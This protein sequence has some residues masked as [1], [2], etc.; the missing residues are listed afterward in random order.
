MR[1]AN[2]AYGLI[3]ASALM[4]VAVRAAATDSAV[5]DDFEGGSNQNKFLAYT[6]YYA[7]TKDGGA[8]VINSA[9]ASGEELLFDAVKSVGEGANGSAKSLK[10][11][12]TYGAVKPTCGTG[13]TYG[14]MAGVG[15][16]FTTDGN[17]LDL[18]GASSV[19]FWAKANAAMT[20]RVEIATSLVTNY[21]YHVF[22]AILTPSWQQYTLPL[23]EGPDFQQ[24]AWAATADPQIFDPSKVEK[25]QFSISADD[26]VGVT[27][28]IVNI[29]NIVVHGY[30]WVP[31]TAC[32][33]CIGA[34]G[35]GVG[36]LL[37][38]LDTAPKNQNTAG[39]YWYAYNDAEGR[40][41][42]AQSEYSEIFEGVTPDT[43]DPTKPIFKATEAKG[44]AGTAAALI[45]FTLGPPYL[46]GTE[47]IKPFVGLGTKLSDNLGVLFT[48]LT[49]ST[50]ISFDYW[51]SAA[52][53]FDY[54]RVEVKANQEYGNAG[55]IH[56]VLLPSTAGTWMSATIPWATFTL[57]D[58]EE[59]KKLPAADKI[60]KIA[61]M[62]KI[63][64]A[65]QGAAGTTGSFAVDNVKVVGLTAIPKIAPI[66]NTAKFQK[67][68]FAVS[69]GFHQVQIGLRMGDKLETAQVRMMD[70]KGHVVASSKFE[71]KGLQSLSLNTQNL[72]SGVYSVQVKVGERM[73]SAPVTLLP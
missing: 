6:F 36:A 65:V 18:T 14:Q 73:L 12:F 26:N 30:K 55:I 59:V 45:S 21:G 39:G 58:W 44:A 19:T 13:C 34:V 16:G 49:G 43:L 4:P 29:D 57:P 40:V 60:L 2:L 7:D 32:I 1:I 72:K 66:H 17:V 24:P 33:P 15:T 11:D 61:A 3:L 52:S 48:D 63:Q 50:G 71:G 54:L 56:S 69:Q 47:S 41:V 10:L 42:A 53:T 70:M 5:V 9:T 20:M 22:Q 8:T 51:S 35:A 64:W 62:D 67:S 23:V 31:P 28:G 27:A 68:G 37:S 46:Q 38:N 25:I